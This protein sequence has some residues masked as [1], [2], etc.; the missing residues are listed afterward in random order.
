MDAL[1]VAADMLVCAGAERADAAKAPARR[2]LLF[3]S[4]SSPVE[5]LDNEMRAAL[6]A[7]LQVRRGGA[8]INRAPR[9]LTDPLADWL[10]RK[11]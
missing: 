9:A 11:P 3:S 2:V 10:E 7:T 6:V 5:A 1:F 8:H 4:F